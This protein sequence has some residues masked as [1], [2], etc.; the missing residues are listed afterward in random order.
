MTQL[1]IESF[2]EG[3]PLVLL[4][5]W[6]FDRRI[7][8]AIIPDVLALPVAHQLILVDLPGFGDSSMLT[9]SEFKDKV[10]A[11]LPEQFILGGWSLG[12]LFATRLASE[13]P[14]RV[15]Q[16]LQIASSPCFIQ[17]SEWPGISPELLDDFYQR[18]MLAPHETRQ[19]FVYAQLG[20]GQANMS[21]LIES[22][23][24]VEHGM[25]LQDGLLAL[26]SWDL[27]ENLLNM[28]T[29]IAY[30]FGRLDRIV[31]YKTMTSLQ[32]K[33]PQ[34]HYT[35]F[36][37]AAHMPFLSHRKEFIDWLKVILC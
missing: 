3:V 1:A 23:E 11:D 31:P 20:S 10:L 6:G 13:A 14:H 24:Q 18:F 12:G 34:G 15:K 22:R 7:W 28:T 29:P 2:G 21:N 9:W 5:G 4:H 35:L 25:G 19:Q 33:Y 8:H 16:L 36:Q 30:L 26:K 32:N 17:H 37:R 27:R